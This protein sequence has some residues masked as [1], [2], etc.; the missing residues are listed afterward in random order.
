[1]IKT[2][3]KKLKRGLWTF[4]QPLS[5][6]PESLRNPV[7]DLF[8]WRNSSKWK[9]YFDLYDIGSFYSQMVKNKE[10]NAKIVF[11]NQSGLKIN[12]HTIKFLCDGSKINE[13]LKMQQICGFKIDIV[14]A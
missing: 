13:L 2:I 6:K 1:M 8:V 5:A 14:Y 9:T 11:F 7:S 10:V 4:K 12:E 3:Y